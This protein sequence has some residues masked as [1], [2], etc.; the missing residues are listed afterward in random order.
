MVGSNILKPSNELLANF[1]YKDLIR[2]NAYVTYYAGSAFNSGATESPVLFVETFRS[3]EETNDVIKAIKEVG[4][5]I[6]DIPEAI[7]GKARKGRK[8]NK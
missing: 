3:K 4:N 6:S 8:A 7:K 5:Q 1:D 2:G